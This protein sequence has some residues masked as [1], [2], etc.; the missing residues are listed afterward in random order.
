MA[1]CSH[2][3]FTAALVFHLDI[4]H[5]LLNTLP[6]LLQ[7]AGASTVAASWTSTASGTTAS[8]ARAGG[9]GTETTAAAQSDTATAAR[10]PPT[11]GRRGTPTDTSKAQ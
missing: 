6:M 10:P 1:G 7:R 3:S 11:Y 4:C 5:L 2:R 8:S 9:R